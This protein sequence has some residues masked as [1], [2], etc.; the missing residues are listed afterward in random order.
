MHN[1][2]Q[3]ALSE[4]T[5]TLRYLIQQH[6][7]DHGDTAETSQKMVLI[8]ALTDLEQA[9]GGIQPFNMVPLDVSRYLGVKTAEA[10]YNTH[11]RDGWELYTVSAALKTEDGEVNDQWEHLLCIEPPHTIDEAII[12]NVLATHTGLDPSAIVVADIVNVTLG[13]P[14]KGKTA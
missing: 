10:L 1:R 8:N 13:Q 3:N 9:I 7:A 6:M 4:Y 14:S 12:I 11:H 2:L 5:D